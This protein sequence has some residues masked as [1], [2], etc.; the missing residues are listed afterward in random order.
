MTGDF[1][2]VHMGNSQSPD[3][4]SG[5]HYELSVLLGARNDAGAAAATVRLWTYPL[6]RGPYASREELLSE[7]PHQLDPTQALKATL[8]GLALFAPNISIPCGS[9]L[10]RFD[11]GNDWIQLY[12]PLG[13]ISAHF[14]TGGFPF[15]RNPQ[16][17]GWEDD[18]DAWLVGV[19][20]H[21]FARARF[22]LAL[23]GF[24]ADIVRFNQYPFSKKV[25]GESDLPK[26][27]M[28]GTL[29][30]HGEE[31]IWHPPNA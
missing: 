10:I 30:P 16:R 7:T 9:S 21:L 27:R 8:Y 22:R 4:W 2:D 12:L 20:K 28:E 23:V 15:G 31:L 29:L 1:S 14:K 6:L 17:M 11:D 13:S 26:R 19:A 25:L 24:E 5:G 18:L 3:L